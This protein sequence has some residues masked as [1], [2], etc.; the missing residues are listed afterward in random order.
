MIYLL[1]YISFTIIHEGGISNVNFVV[2]GLF[3]LNGLLTLFAQPLIYLYERIFK[4]VS[5]VSLLELSDTNSKLLKDLSNKAPGSFHHSL[6]VANLAE[7]AAAKIGAN[8][9][10]AR[11]GAIYHEIGKINTING[12]KIIGVSNLMNRLPLTASNL[13]AKNLFSFIRNLFSKEKKSFNINMQDEIIE[14]TLIKEAK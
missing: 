8:T 11:V 10:L 14:K 13:Y 6:Q 3:L 9:L 7:T 2:I 5:D 12:I 4:L 1:C